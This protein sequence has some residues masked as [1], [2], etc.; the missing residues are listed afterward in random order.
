MI[1][2]LN[3]LRA[4]LDKNLKRSAKDLQ[5]ALSNLEK[6]KRVA[7]EAT[8]AHASVEGMVEQSKG[9]F[10]TMPTT[11]V[12]ALKTKATK[13]VAVAPKKRGR[14]KKE[15][16]VKAVAAKASAKAA[17]IPKVAA[18][19][20]RGRPKKVVEAAAAP[21]RGPGRPKKVV[22]AAATAPKK[23]GRPK[24]VVAETAAAAPKKRGRPK[25]EVA[26]SSVA[27]APKKRGRPKKEATADTVPK[28]RG[29]PKNEESQ[30]TLLGSVKAVMGSSTLG[31]KEILAGLKAIGATPD[32]NNPVAMV[33]TALSIGTK[34]GLFEKVQHGKYRVA[35]PAATT[36][37]AVET[38][39]AAAPTVVESVDD[40]MAS[41]GY[42]PGE[43]AAHSA[44]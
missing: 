40:V 14:P 25:K 27:A 23:R 8:E 39:P 28:K 12:K 5:T 29:R 37:P 2:T 17:K 20:K 7:H 24:K 43:L 42:D 16:V 44:L 19:K 22:E 31:A 11:K 26:A 9:L 36:K 41:L 15:V 1:G 13:T 34:K 33:H 6:A 30:G 4:E 3:K 21:K 35:K 38:A 18:P 10:A 32:S